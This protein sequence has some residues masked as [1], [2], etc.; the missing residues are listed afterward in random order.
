MFGEPGATLLVDYGPD[1]DEEI[2]IKK[3]LFDL[4]CEYQEK[5]DPLVKRLAEIRE[6]KTPRY[7]V[8]TD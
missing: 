5:V 2:K 6:T 8:V 3:K 7:V 1:T 4:R